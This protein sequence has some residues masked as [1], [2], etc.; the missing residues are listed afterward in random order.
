MVFKESFKNFTSYYDSSKEDDVNFYSMVNWFRD[1]TNI[2]SFEGWENIP[3][4][5]TDIRYIFYGTDI[6]SQSETFDLSK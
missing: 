3:S 2:R 6:Q 5:V 1:A 4:C